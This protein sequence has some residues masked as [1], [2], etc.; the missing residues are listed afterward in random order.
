MTLQITYKQMVQLKGLACFTHTLTKFCH[1]R[2]AKER[3]GNI[4]NI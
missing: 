2:T 1:P 4:K 3:Q